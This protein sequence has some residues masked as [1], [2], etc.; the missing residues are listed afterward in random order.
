MK[1]FLKFIF[2][3]PMM[4]LVASCSGDDEP[5]M[6]EL[7]GEVENGFFTN[8]ITSNEFRYFNCKKVARYRKYDSEDKWQLD[9]GIYDGNHTPDQSFLFCKGKLYFMVDW[10]AFYEGYPEFGYLM[11]LYRDLTE[12]GRTYPP[13]FVESPLN[14]NAADK[15]LSYIFCSYKTT[16]KVVNAGGDRFRLST[17]SN[18]TNSY[19][20]GLFMDI[21]DFV[22]DGLFY[23][24]GKN[25]AYFS[26]WKELANYLVDEAET[27][28]GPDYRLEKIGPTLSEVREFYSQDKYGLTE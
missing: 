24:N 9:E 17:E 4:L 6:P 3:L 7:N 2:L 5:D 13:F 16:A 11:L 26:S 21:N 27:L 25:S 23:A 14:Y 1:R 18:F 12:S 10:H 20:D 19:G 28:F 15:E 22:E 8:L